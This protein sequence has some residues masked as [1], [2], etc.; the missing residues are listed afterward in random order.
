MSNI[1]IIE[2]SLER[3]LIW[4]S[5]IYTATFHKQ[6]GIFVIFKTFALCQTLFVLFK[7]QTTEIQTSNK[8]FFNFFFSLKE[9]WPEGV[10][11]A[12]GAS[13]IACP[14]VQDTHTT[15]GVRYPISTFQSGLW[16]NR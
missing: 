13:A 9:T 8:S 12:I 7:S 6:Q 11:E 16:Y 15:L 2:F 10:K 3:A 5:L 14:D 1:S 4:M